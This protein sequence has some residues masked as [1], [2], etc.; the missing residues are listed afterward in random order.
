MATGPLSTMH[1]SVDTCTKMWC[2]T[3]WRRPTVISVSTTQPPCSVIYL[4]FYTHSCSGVTNDA[5]RTPLD[6]ATQHGYTEIVDYLKSLPQLCK[7]MSIHSVVQ[8]SALSIQLL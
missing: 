4:C 8:Y 6:Y 3:W 2:S 1:A 5:G 7:I